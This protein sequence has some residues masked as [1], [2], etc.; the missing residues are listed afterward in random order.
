MT[1]IWLRMAIFYLDIPSV[2][3]TVA[4]I[5]TQSE[6]SKTFTLNQIIKKK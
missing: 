4:R 2:R 6:A 5:V 3:K 1:T